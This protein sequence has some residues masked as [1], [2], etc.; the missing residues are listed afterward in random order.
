M[1][2]TV[3]ALL[4]VVSRVV[5]SLGSRSDTCR[6]DHVGTE[7]IAGDC[8]GGAVGDE[9]GTLGISGGWSRGEES[10]CGGCSALVVLY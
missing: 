1:L 9:E 3:V 8:G 4:T 5:E 2:K 7:S 6:C 10:S